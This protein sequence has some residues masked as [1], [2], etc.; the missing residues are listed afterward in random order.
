MQVWRGAIT[1][2]T[3]FNCDTMQ[4]W[5]GAITQRAVRFEEQRLLPLTTKRLAWAG[6]Y[7]LP[8]AKIQDRTVCYKC[9]KALHTWAPNRLGTRCDH[10]HRKTKLILVVFHLVQI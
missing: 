3:T 6:L 9:G 2:K 8:D 4:V 7:Y 1:H 10:F 5:R